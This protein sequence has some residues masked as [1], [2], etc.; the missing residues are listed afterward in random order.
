ML[1]VLIKGPTP[2]EQEQLLLVHVAVVIVSRV[3][4][5][6]VVKPVGFQCR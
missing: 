6:E 2:W 4:R 3:E 1:P 5:L